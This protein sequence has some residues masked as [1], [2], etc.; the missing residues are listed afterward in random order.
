[1]FA[2]TEEQLACLERRGEPPAP[3]VPGPKGGRRSEEDTEHNG[4]DKAY[5]TFL[6]MPY[7]I[8]GYTFDQDIVLTRSDIPGVQNVDDTP[9]LQ[10][11]ISIAVQSA[12]NNR[13]SVSERDQPNGYAG[14][15]ETSKISTSVLPFDY[16]HYMGTWD[17]NGNIPDISTTTPNS[18]SYYLVSVA[19]T[20]L[21]ITWSVNDVCIYNGSNWQRL[22]SSSLVASVNGQIGIVNLTKSDVSLDQVDNTSDTS[23]PVSIAQQALIDDRTQV[24]ED[25]HMY[26]RRNNAWEVIS[27][28][29]LMSVNNDSLLST[30]SKIYIHDSQTVPTI[31]ET[32]TLTLES[33]HAYDALVYPGG[34]YATVKAAVND[35]RRNILV[36]QS[37][38]E[39]DV[40]TIGQDISI[41]LNP[42]VTWTCKGLNV[43][44]QNIVLVGN[45]L[46]KIVWTTVTESP[47]IAG[48]ST[49][50]YTRGH[51]IIDLQQQSAYRNL[52]SN[53]LGFR[54][55]GV[56][57]LLYGD[58]NYTNIQLDRSTIDVLALTSMSLDGSQLFGLVSCSLTDFNRVE[59]RGKF[60]DM[61][62]LVDFYKCDVKDFHIYDEYI[63]S[64]NGYH[65]QIGGAVRSLHN[66]NDSNRVYVKVNNDLSIF[67]NMIN[68][69]LDVNGKQKVMV[70]TSNVY[71]SNSNSTTTTAC[72]IALS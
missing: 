60:N 67:T 64:T 31:S 7:S 20:S 5:I 61:D 3:S 14:L 40:F 46:S 52:L 34:N 45:A 66:I 42:R 12:L 17:A 30:I 44:S 58:V 27:S 51:V 59:L 29:I 2:Y 57:E 10:K 35:Q 9:D 72:I 38:E 41:S 32:S 22:P 48:I 71:V 65:L 49:N 68:T 4:K 33:Q 50:V 39:E 53:I 24:P 16:M 1:M 11:P 13:Q 63:T 18:G 37:V 56:L 70:S 69:I 6:F 28:D 25:G 15:N 55:T 47:L 8:N 62:L 36:I 54:V 19:G 21:A 26:G 23:K 43:Q